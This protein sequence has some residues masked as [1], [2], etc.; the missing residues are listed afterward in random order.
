MLDG[1]RYPPRA[2]A[3]L[4][5]TMRSWP[6]PDCPRVQGVAMSE[7]RSPI[8]ITGATGR[9]GGRIARRLAAAGVPQRLLVRDPARAPELPAAT[10][11][12]APYGDRDAVREALT[13]VGTVLMVSASETPDRVAQHRT[14]VDAA[15]DAGVDQLVYISF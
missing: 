6:H 2:A 14:F 8:A 15:V 10:A 9:L 1:S 11:V 4:F 12:R 7:V 5:S 3:G 13:G